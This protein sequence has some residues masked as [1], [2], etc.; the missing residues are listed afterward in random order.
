MS[1]SKR[2][3]LI[4]YKNFYINLTDTYLNILVF[5]PLTVNGNQF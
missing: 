4:F 2:N 5:N 1:Q 3:Y